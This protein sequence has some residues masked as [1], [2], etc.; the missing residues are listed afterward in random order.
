L[1][2]FSEHVRVL[3]WK[4]GN[5]HTIKN[6]LAIQTGVLN[7]PGKPVKC[8]PLVS[9]VSERCFCICSHVSQLRSTEG[10]DADKGA[11]KNVVSCVNIN[12]GLRGF[13][14]LYQRL[15]KGFS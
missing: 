4:G 9:E 2:S 14:N 8:L 3:K 1:Y 13:I 10:T 11:E 12:D 7:R 15:I 6:G 5:C